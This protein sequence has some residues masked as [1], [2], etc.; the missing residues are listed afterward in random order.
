[1][2]SS[3]Y[4]TGWAAR[5]HQDA[6]TLIELLVVISII[7]II[8]SM[9]MPAIAMVRESAYATSCQSTLRQFGIANASYAAEWEGYY[10]AGVYSDASGT[11][12]NNWYGNQVYADMMGGWVPASLPN[13]FKWATKLVCPRAKEFGTISQANLNRSYGYFFTDVSDT[14][15]GHEP[16]RMYSYRPEQYRTLSETVM[17]CDFVSWWAGYSSNWYVSEANLSTTATRHRG[18]A[19]FLYADIHV[20]SLN[21]RIV[22]A[23]TNTDPLWTI[24]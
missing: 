22:M 24:Q 20:G 5:A 21:Q 3:L 14:F 12:T 15:S 13:K 2:N 7:A 8:A 18:R 9:L 6:F 17:F 4:R 11:Q 23:K 16:N 10:V 19:S 1:M